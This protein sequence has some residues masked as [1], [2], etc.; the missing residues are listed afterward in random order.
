MD[1]VTDQYGNY[2]IQHILQKGA[3]E[4]RSAIIAQVRGHVLDMSK[5][6]FAS[7]V[8]E[9]CF[10]FSTT[11]EKSGLVDEMVGDER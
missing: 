6:K 1:L 3:L 10:A 4:Y 9:K 7:N 5:H 8:I 2:V 11:D